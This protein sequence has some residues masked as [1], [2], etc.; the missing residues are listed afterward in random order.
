MLAEWVLFFMIP[1]KKRRDFLKFIFASTG[2]KK[3]HFTPL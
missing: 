1:I 2:I 3:L